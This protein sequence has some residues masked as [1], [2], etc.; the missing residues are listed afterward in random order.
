MLT[1]GSEDAEEVMSWLVSACC[2]PAEYLQPDQQY[3]EVE[4]GGPFEEASAQSC[5]SPI[6][7][8]QITDLRLKIKDDKTNI[9]YMRSGLTESD[10]GPEE[11][12]ER[13]FGLCPFSGMTRPN[14]SAN[15]SLSLNFGWLK[16][17]PR[18]SF[19]GT[20]LAMTERMT[21]SYEDCMQILQLLDR[22]LGEF[23]RHMWSPIM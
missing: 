6:R 10:M 22:P 7:T 14:R 11:W 17:L 12:Q 13:C 8:L 19:P 15:A 20:N 4:L 2:R 3:D 16:G 21:F 23:V 1:L 18:D 5:L 9:S